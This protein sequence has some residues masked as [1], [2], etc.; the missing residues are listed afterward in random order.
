MRHPFRL[1]SA[2]VAAIGLV[3]AGVGLAAAPATA[4][5]SPAQPIVINEVYGGGGNSGGLLQPR[6]H[7]A[8]QRLCQPG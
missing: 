6:L 5:V 7:R 4:A 3:L 2:G 8:A 1:W